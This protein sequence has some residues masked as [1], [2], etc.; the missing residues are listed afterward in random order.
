MAPPHLSTALR[1]IRTKSNGGGKDA[2]F[3]NMEKAS[4]QVCQT[5]TD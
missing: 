1:L 2:C 4:V 5:Q 3:P